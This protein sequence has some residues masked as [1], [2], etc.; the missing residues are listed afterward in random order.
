MEGNS[1]PILE[2]RYLQSFYVMCAQTTYVD[3]A[4][5]NETADLWHAHFGHVDYNKLEV[6]IKKS[7]LK[8]LP[9]LDVKEDIVCAG[10]QFGK[11]HQLPYED[12]KFKS[13]EPLDLVHSD[14][15]GPLKQRLVSCVCYMITFIEDLRYI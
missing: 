8:G 2:G 10:C 1:Y 7:M 5:K 6:M 14:V 11:A 3:K 4:R 9:Q 12:S 13:K 15:F